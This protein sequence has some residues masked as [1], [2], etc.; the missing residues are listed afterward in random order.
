VC[1]S[2]FR[3]SRDHPSIIPFIAGLLGLISAVDK[4]VSAVVR[5]GIYPRIAFTLLASIFFDAKYAMRIYAHGVIPPLGSGESG[6]STI[7]KQMKIIHQNGYTREELLSFRPLIWKNLLESARDVILA[8]SKFNLEPITPA[9]KVRLVLIS[10]AVSRLTPFG[11]SQANCERIMN[12][13]LA[14]DDSHFF[15]S[16][17]IAQFVQDVWG[18]E[19]I[20]ALMDHSSRFYLM[21]S[22]S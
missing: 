14:T 5:V 21:D 7:V 12:Y 20:P 9:N 22:A 18:D 3:T 6:K 8:L 16:P 17:E 1:H 2:I 4:H 13:H 11:L 19:I 10:S 15:F